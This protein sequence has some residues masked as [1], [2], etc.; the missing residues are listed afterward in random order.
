M[1]DKAHR[2]LID[3]KIEWIFLLSAYILLDRKLFDR[4]GSRVP[5]LF[6]R[7][8]GIISESTRN[9]IIRIYEI[10]TSDAWGFSPGQQGDFLL[11]PLGKTTRINTHKSTLYTQGVS[12]SWITLGFY[13]NDEKKRGRRKTFATLFARAPWLYYCTLTFTHRGKTHRNWS[14][15]II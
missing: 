14:C 2:K 9:I 13:V 11:L 7:K 6:K 10:A 8:Y 1:Y 4:T 12:F 5:H 3:T 15:R